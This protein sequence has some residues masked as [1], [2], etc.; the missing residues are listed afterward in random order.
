MGESGDYTK[1][2]EAV[3]Q[4]ETKLTCTGHRAGSAELNGAKPPE[5]LS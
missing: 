3:L 5:P 1:T 4:A 2:R